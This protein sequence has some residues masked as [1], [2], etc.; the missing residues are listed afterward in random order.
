MRETLREHGQHLLRVFSFVSIRDG[1]PY[2][3]ARLH[4]ERR[5]QKRVGQRAAVRREAPRQRRCVSRRADCPI[6]D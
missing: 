3:V 1:E 2:L 5:R 6:L 4:V